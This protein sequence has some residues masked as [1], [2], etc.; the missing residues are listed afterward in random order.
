MGR[1]SAPAVSLAG[2]ENSTPA[3]EAWLQAYRTRLEQACSRPFPEERRE[4]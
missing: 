1:N 4:S 2:P 3:F